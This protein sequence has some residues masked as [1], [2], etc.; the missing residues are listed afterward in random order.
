MLDGKMIKRSK[1]LLSSIQKMINLKIIIVLKSLSIL[2]ILKDKFLNHLLQIGRNTITTLRAS[3][4]DY[5]EG[6]VA[7]KIGLNGTAR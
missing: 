5:Q 6:G 2:K 1:I 3:R 7:F 4:C